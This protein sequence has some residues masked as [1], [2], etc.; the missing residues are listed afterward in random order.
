MLEILVSPARPPA[1]ANVSLERE[2]FPRWIGHGLYGYLAPGPFLD[3][4]TPEDFSAAERFFASLRESRPR[5]FIVLDRDGTIIKEREYL[6]DPE[7]V[8]LIPG[9]G[10]SLRFDRHHQSVGDRTRLVRS[11][12]ATT[13][14]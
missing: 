3:I 1:R 7:Q 10:A 2:V 4:G 8:T 13:C 12:P 11:G 9:V 14:S 6:S 5:P